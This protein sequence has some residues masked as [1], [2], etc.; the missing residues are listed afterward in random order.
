MNTT[1]GKKTIMSD[2]T[3]YADLTLGVV[4]SQI[5]EP[6]E[7]SVRVENGTVDP[8]D[9]HPTK[10]EI[11]SVTPSHGGR[12]ASVTVSGYGFQT[13]LDVKLGG[14]AAKHVVIDPHTV[15]FDVPDVATGSQALEIRI[16]DAIYSYSAH[17]A[18]TTFTVD[19]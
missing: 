14:V 4:D 10:V 15:V 18:D 5:S 6:S 3:R 17:R 19:A 9:F 2:G 11:V 7:R 1:E 13:Y 16:K 12:G 8:P